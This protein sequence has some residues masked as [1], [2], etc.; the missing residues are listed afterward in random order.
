MYDSKNSYFAN[1]RGEELAEAVLDRVERYDHFA[2]NSFLQ[3]LWR[4][5]LDMYY[6]GAAM[7]RPVTVGENGEYVKVSVNQYRNIVRHLL[8]TT[9]GTR[10]AFEPQAVNMDYKSRAQVEVCGTM[11]DY[12]YEA[13]NAEVLFDR[14]VEFALALG[15]GFIVPRWDKNI[16]K[17]TSMAPALHPETQEALL[18]PNT[19]DY[20]K[21][22]QYAGDLT[23][24]AATPADVIRDP[25]ADSWEDL[26]WV[27]VREPMNRWDLIA[28]Y[29][30]KRME[31]LQAPSKYE[32]WEKTR[33]APL[34][35]LNSVMNR[36]S[37][38][39]YIFTL[40]HKLSPAVPAGKAVL[41]LNDG[42]TVLE[43]LSLEDLGLPEIPVH[44]VSGGDIA[45]MPFGYSNMFDLLALQ[46]IYNLLIS[47]ITT[48]QSNFGV[49]SLQC[50][51][52]QNLDVSQLAKGLMVIK[53]TNPAGKLE[54]LVLGS[55]P[56]EVFAFLK[57]IEKLF[58]T[59]SG[60]NSVARGNPEAS[61]ESGAALAL[62]QAQHIE[63]TK[64]LQRS[65]GYIVADTGTTFVRL[66]RKYSDSPRLAAIVGKAGHSYLREMKD[67]ELTNIDR[68]KV[69]MGSYLARTA[70]GRVNQAEMLSRANMIESPEQFLTVLNTGRLEPLTHSRQST[71]NLIAEENE[72]LLMGKKPE[73]MIQDN[74][75][76][77]ILEHAAVVSN[78]EA[79]ENA[80]VIDAVTAHINEHIF[81]LTN[82]PPVLAAILKMPVLNQQ[83][84]TP[85]PTQ[86]QPGPSQG[87]P[88][89]IGGAPDAASGSQQA[90]M[91]AA[92]VE[93]PQ[94][95]V[96]GEQWDPATGGQ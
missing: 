31:I 49:S 8:V 22:P 63:Y 50:L 70:A 61:L 96:T 86:G 57:D 5:S 77:H 9:T 91:E 60:V 65:Y 58:E 69:D 80:G 75:A 87:Q 6:K 82:L 78:L 12:Y 39:V 27:V 20:I 74:H 54:P 95:P 55:T 29:P 32:S 13:T 43:E 19:E 84:G 51:A 28:R 26:K 33:I 47:Q 81:N 79:R 85:A 64:D 48:N 7:N 30:F 46:D 4:R 88:K 66:F 18:D 45:G 83:P 52:G 42:K 68:V 3:P 71:L 2:A 15:E 62:V 93:F 72:R 10:P 59:L 16:G 40:Y 34:Q 73:V 25:S 92:N 1:L 24:R 14:A 53:Y 36:E 89:P 21:V 11:L 23:A 35:S 44:R 67:L 41:M 56:Q 90:Q 38:D 94:N 76:L 37:E 17:L